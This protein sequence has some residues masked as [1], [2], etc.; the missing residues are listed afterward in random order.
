MASSGV[1]NDM[2]VEKLAQTQDAD[3]NSVIMM[4]IDAGQKSSLHFLL[5]LP[6]HFRADHILN[7]MN[8]DGVTLLSAAVQSGNVPVTEELLQYL[9][10][11]A[12]DDQLQQYLAIQDSKGRCVGH[13][14]FNQPHLIQR[15]GRK[16]PWR[17]KDKNGQ[18]PLFALS[19]SYDHDQYHSMIETALSL[20]TETQ[21]DG[22]PL[23]HDDHVDAKGNTLLH[24]INDTD[25]TMRLLRSSDVD[26]NA[27]NDKR[28]T[29][30]MVGSKYGRLDLVRVLFGDPRT[31]TT[32]RDLRGLSAVELA[33]DDDVRN[34]FDDLVLLS[35]ANGSDER[36]TKIVRSFFVEDGT[37]RL[38]LKSG[39]KNPN[40]T[41]TVNTCRRTPEDFANLSKWLHIECPAS[42]LPTQF[43]LASPFLIPGKPSRALLRDTQI[44][45][46]NFFRTL[47]TH[48]TFATHELVWE[49]FL[50]PEIDGDMLLER[51]KRKAE[52]RVDNLKDDFEP[53]TDTRASQRRHRNHAPRHPHRKSTPHAPARLL[54]I[55]TPRFKRCL[56]ACLPATNPPRRFRTLHP[57]PRPLRSEPH[58]KLL[59]HPALNPQHLNRDPKRP[60]PP[61]NSDRKHGTIPTHHLTNPQF[62]LARQSLDARVR[63]IRRHQESRGAGRLE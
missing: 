14:V 6:A 19:R 12:S 52:A 47:L 45:L 40:G 39:A 10:E 25:I 28:F 31:D 7:D 43:N 36:T 38:V 37:V 42:W 18:T 51:S 20:A 54:R 57:L 9:E 56:D 46:D 50:V 32:L 27:A 17:L 41:I 16:L 49:F 22:Q 60:R 55:R 5:S 63:L 29:P 59:L 1:V 11:N 13:Y 26:V 23:H 2:S 35:V 48:A 44:R 15:F 62:S 53:I 33:K 34:R 3:G 4:A 61:R 21:G 30:L 8:D 58:D 24:I